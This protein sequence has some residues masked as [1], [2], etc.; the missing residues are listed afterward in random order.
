MGSWDKGVDYMT[1]YEML[2]R[3]IKRT[4]HP[5][6]C[7][8]IVGL[9]QLRNGSRVSEA[10]R[11]FKRWIYTGNQELHVDVSKKKH[12][13]AR[14]MIIPKEVEEYRRECLDIANV[15]DEVLVSRVKWALRYY[16][17]INTHSL[18]YA[19]ITFL[20]REGVNPAIVSKLIH[21]SRL[22]TIMKYV[23]EKA[24]EEVLKKIY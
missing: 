11:A 12:P 3:Y 24:G 4:K 13:E 17:K 1:T 21:H 23:Q 9:I 22:D 10:V 20:L 15:E 18:R 14:L 2:L 8:L 16:L 5:G 6:K 7:Y 19:Y